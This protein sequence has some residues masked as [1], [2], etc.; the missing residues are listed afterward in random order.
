MT[1]SVV[2]YFAMKI[3]GPL[4]NHWVANF[5]AQHPNKLLQKFAQFVN[6]FNQ[7]VQATIAGQQ[8]NKVVLVIR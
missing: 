1:C 4:I 3:F 6:E 7:A 2:I 5:S 8:F